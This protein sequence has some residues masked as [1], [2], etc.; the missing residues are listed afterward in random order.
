MKKDISR[1]LVLGGAAVSMAL[2]FLPSALWS[3]RV[4]AAACTPPR[5]F[6]AWFVPNGFNM[7]DWT[8]T[9]AGTTWTPTPI[10]MP[11][12]VIRKKMLI[13]TGLDMQMTAVPA[14]PPGDHGAGTGSFI[15]M[16]PVNG[17]ETDKTRVSLDQ[18]LL[19]AL[20]PVGCAQ[21]L[22]PSLQLGVQGDNGL[23]DRTSCDFSRAIS[24]KAGVPMPNIYDPALLFDKLFTGFSPG[25]STADAAQR[26]AERTSILDRVLAQ[27]QALS[28]KLSTSDKQK[29]EEFQS[30]VRTLELRLKAPASTVTCDAKPMRPA[31][32][33]PL[34]F[35]RGITPS[36]ILQEHVPNFITLMTIAFK[37]DMTRSITFM[38]GNGTSNNDFAFVTG[39]PTPHHGTSHHMGNASSIA[40]LTKIDI[41]ET[42]QI[43]TFLKGLDDIKESDGTSILDNLTFYMGSDIGDGN[44]HNHWD[45]PVL[46]A[47]GASGKL[48]TDG[49]HI[50]YL[51]TMKFPRPL[52]GDQGG[53]HT[54]RV[55]M[56][57]LA[58]HGMPSTTFGTATGGPLTELM[59]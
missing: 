39:S 36:S 38:L 59:A 55:L 25:A 34:N 24:W 7:P 2:P 28:T 19:P 27:S 12:E 43:A 51:P 3:R 56:A 45:Q 30:S 46:L 13:L 50:N 15:N 16:I 40:K 17:H 6:M 32:S 57:I 54:G 37:C 41:W 29:L 20:N 4:N 14:N 18:V 8:P 53:P 48:K 21:P 49:R 1:R 22:L 26:T 44:S 58:A 31:M 23:C 11:L 9:T 5:R 10:S 33:P 42:T 47:G 35:D 52:V